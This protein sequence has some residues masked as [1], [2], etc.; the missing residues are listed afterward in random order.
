MIQ[1]IQTLYL[2]AAVVLS[3]ACLCLKIGVFSFGGFTILNEYNLWVTDAMG[4]RRFDTWPLFSVLVLSAAMGIYSIFMFNN[5]ILQARF[6]LFNVLLLLGWY[7]LYIVYG[8]ILGDGVERVSFTPALS[9][10]LPACAIV[11][12]MRARK[13]ILSDEKLVRAADRIR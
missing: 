9:G 6:C 3:V 10:I 8:Q 11:L 4:T 7:I 13:A 1:R 2:I 5:R 12:Y